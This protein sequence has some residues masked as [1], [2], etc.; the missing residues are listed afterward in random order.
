MKAH[1]FV[2]GSRATRTQR[3]ISHV[4]ITIT[5]DALPTAVVARIECEIDG[6]LTP[7]PFD[8]S[9]FSHRDTPQL[10]SHIERVGVTISQRG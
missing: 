6:L 2:S 5:G 10:L 8:I 4:D 7:Y 9:S 1:H 3:A